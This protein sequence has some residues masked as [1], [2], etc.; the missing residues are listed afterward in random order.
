MAS[1]A[2]ELMLVCLAPE[3]Y[4]LGYRPGRATVKSCVVDVEQRLGDGTDMVQVE[5]DRI[6]MVFYVTSCDWSILD[7]H[8]A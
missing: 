4:A 3:S 7:N 1:G 5:D 8:E 2:L 6:P